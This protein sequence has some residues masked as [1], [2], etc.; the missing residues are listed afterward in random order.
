MN[1]RPRLLRIPRLAILTCLSFTFVV[2]AGAASTSQQ[3]SLQEYIFELDKCSALLASSGN[4]P[5]VLRTW[6]MSLPGQWIVNVGNQTYTVSTD[7]LTDGLARTETARHGDATSLEQTRQQIAVHRNAAEA[8]STAS[9]PQTLDESRAKLNHI[10]AGKAFQAIHGPTWFEV[11]RARFYDWV[12]RQLQKLFGRLRGGRVIGNVIAWTV[13][14]LAALLL[15]L[16]AV[17]ATIRTGARPEMDLRG[18]AGPGRDSPYWLREARDAAARGDYR[19]AIH[20]AYWAA[21]ARLEE[22]KS[23]PED[24]SRTPRESLRLIRRES[25]EYAPLSQLTRRFELVWYGYRSANSAD[26]SDAMQQLET[27]GCLRSST[28]AISAS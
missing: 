10:L 12:V 23:L 27:L 26:W 9:S 13:I 17:R 28:P 2:R 24:R 1:L 3:L 14:A 19:A 6:R 8:L 18:A 7:W 21:I 20:A 15:I 4:N 25:A 11:L 16:W 5:A 22:M